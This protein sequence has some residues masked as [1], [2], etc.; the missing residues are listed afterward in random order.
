MTHF[1][2]F[3]SLLP[4]L[5][6]GC[7]SIVLINTAAA[8]S[9]LTN[10]TDKITVIGKKHHNT[11]APHHQAEYLHATDFSP[12]VTHLA[13][14]VA[15][16][17]GA[18]L[19]GQGGLFQVYSLRGMSKWRV[20]TH[21][22]GTPINTERRA[23]TAASFIAPWLLE[24][25][26]V[27][28][29]PVSTLYGS[30]G[31]GGIT[32]LT[33]RQFEGIH[34]KANLSA[35]DH[36]HSQHFGWG[37]EQLSVA[38]SHRKNRNGQTP[39][40]QPLNNHF[41]QF[42]AQLITNWQIQPALQSQLL[43]FTSKGK[44]IGKTNNEDFIN[45]KSTDYPKETHH[46]VRWGLVSDNQWQAHL[47]IHQQQ[48]IT[49][50]TRFDQR[51][52][53]VNNQA[54]DL[55]FSVLK[56]WEYDDLNGQWGLEHEYRNGIEATEQERSLVG[57]DDQN[58]QLLTATQDQS[59]IF[60]DLNY[61]HG[62]WSFSLGGRFSYQEQHSPLATTEPAN[63]YDHAITSFASAA[64]Q[65]N[66]QWQISSAIST[67]LRFPSVTERFYQGTTARGTTLGNP[68]LTAETA[69]N[70]ELGF[71][72]TNPTIRWDMQLFHNQI[73]DY[74]ERINL[75]DEIRTY[76]NVNQ[77]TIRGVE[78]GFD[79]QINSRFK[80]HISAHSIEGQDQNGVPLADITAN[81]IQLGLQI[82]HD[83]WHG[84]LSI[85]HRFAQTQVAA[86]DQP[87]AAVDIVKM[88]F[89]YDLTPHWQLAFWGNN[90]LNKDYVVTTDSKSA[91]AAERQW[92][93][94]V[95]WQMD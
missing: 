28:K 49:Q 31:M 12:D 57:G 80:Y 66:K 48:L 67:G 79:Y 39:S 3:Y 15:N 72:Y 40:G 56:F 46:I 33:P 90:L 63:S 68:Q 44:D 29:G 34:L 94:S 9:T 42:N 10:P 59:A 30:G 26:E 47:A 75:S 53:R 91:R 84:Q 73:S 83:R 20:L 43:A 19:S 87:L 5:A 61:N 14:L 35:Q 65:I 16:V 60:A 25:V 93:I 88:A 18:E 86:G 22:A 81:K 51:I 27:L 78:L 55:F 38:L 21:Y 36:N 89:H 6:I 76:K 92:G 4:W 50:I 70:F 17:P 24:H 41:Q 71:G 82:D 74:I 69:T 85:K 32:Q 11:R 37:N 77:G 23:G 52:N 7:G 13:E 45:T 1:P 2:F 54:T 64:Y 95:A 8:S 62:Q 58:Y